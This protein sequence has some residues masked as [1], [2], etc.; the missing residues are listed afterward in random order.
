MQELTISLSENNLKISTIEKGEFK[1]VV[2]ELSN[3]VAKDHIILNEESFSNSVSDLLNT[4]TSKRPK[5]LSLNFLVEPS[6]VYLHFVTTNK[7]NED[8]EQQIRNEVSTK[9]SDTNLDELYFSYYKIAPFVYQFV[10]IKKQLLE[11][12]MNISNSLGITLRSVLPWILYLP[13]F[14]D[15]NEPAIF[16]S[17]VSNKQIVALSEFGSI[18]FSGVYEQEKNT[19]ELQKLVTELSVYKRNSP[20]SRVYR[21]KYDS[22]SLNPDY[23]VLDLQVPNSDLEQAQGYELHLLVEYVLDK[24]SSLLLT[25]MNLLNTLPLPE[26][27]SS[28]PRALV[29]VKALAGVLL[30]LGFGFSAFY[31]T[32]D[33]NSSQEVLQNTT[34]ENQV[35]SEETQVADTQTDG[36]ESEQPLEEI[37][38]DKNELVIRVENGAGLPG[39]AGRTQEYL[40]TREYT[41]ASVGNSDSQNRQTTLLQFKESKKDFASLVQKDMEE[42]FET[43]VGDNLDESAEY[44]LLITVGVDAD[45]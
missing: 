25:P 27:I 34:N 29:P 10:G 3:D 7:A 45:L 11:Q 39:I 40:E 20:I 43:E 26:D 41:V 17:K 6:D 4:I 24:D 2:A 12:Y 37:T 16:I 32:N 23:E 8:L 15:T 38:L 33:N 9:L 44:D 30:L 28:K 22:F 14:V 21:F 31:L 36:D 18:F 42:T 5:D 1:G 35:L 19:E 13:K